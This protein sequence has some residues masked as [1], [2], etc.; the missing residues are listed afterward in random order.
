MLG[1]FLLS[2]AMSR[3]RLPCA[4]SVAGHLL[5]SIFLAVFCCA[6]LAAAALAA[7]QAGDVP[8]PPPQAK[9]LIVRL[10]DKW[11]TLDAEFRSEEKRIG[12]EMAIWQSSGQPGGRLKDLFERNVTPRSLYEKLIQQY[13]NLKEAARNSRPAERNR[14]FPI[15]DAQCVLNYIGY[16]WAL[17]KE[18]FENLESQLRGRDGQKLRDRIL[19]ALSQYK[20]LAPPPDPELRARFSIP[21]GY[22]DPPGGFFA[23]ISKPLSVDWGPKCL[24]SD[25]LLPDK[26]VKPYRPEAAALI[27][28]DGR[29]GRRIYCTG[30][31]IAPNAVLTAAHCVCDTPA[32]DPNGVFFTNASECRAGT[33]QRQGRPVSTL[34]P[35]YDSVYFQHAGEF[36]VDRIVVHP[37]FRWSARSFADLAIFFLKGN[38]K[39]IQPAELNGVRALPPGTDAPTVGFGAHNP[40]GSSGRITT[41]YEIVENTG[42]KLETVPR[43]SRCSFYERSRRLICWRYSGDSGEINA[44]STCRGDSGGP[45][46]ADF[47]GKTYLAGVTSGGGPSCLPNNDASFDT[48]VFAFRNWIRSQL[49]YGLFRQ[50]VLAYKTAGAPQEAGLKQLICYFCPFCVQVSGDIPIQAR[51]R[52]LR[53]SVNCTSDEFARDSQIKV[54]MRLKPDDELHPIDNKGPSCNP[55]SSTVSCTAQVKPGQTWQVEVDTGLLQQCQIVATSNE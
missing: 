24:Q 50:W 47:N 41:P 8:I 26:T 16:F 17:K 14:D 10:K 36:A 18:E 43:T 25:E 38:V 19:E 20:R 48:E 22:D 32:K 46:Y 12:R 35:S 7:G 34:D 49:G 31:L 11:K 30:T 55:K 45:L 3:F 40:I 37:Q 15:K 52:Q 51:A 29:N 9:A 5:R 6:P 54:L 53:V 44:G 39:G 2:V 28:N 4:F 42:L 13:V 1:H 23:L 27:Y 33:Y 21:C